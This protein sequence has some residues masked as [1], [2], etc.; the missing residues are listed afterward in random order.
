MLKYK[1]L[2]FNTDKEQDDSRRLKAV[3]E[4]DKFGYIAGY[5]SVFG[6]VDSAYDTVQRGAFAASI[7]AKMPKMLWQH[8][9]WQPIGIWDVVREDDYGL[10]VEG[11][12]IKN[13]E[14]PQ[15]RTAFALLKEG[16]ING[17][18]IGYR[19]IDTE[20]NRDTGIQTLIA[21]DLLEVSIVTFPANDLAEVANV[22]AQSLF[23]G[24]LKKSMHG[25]LD[26]LREFNKS[27]LNQ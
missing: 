25:L 7:A 3:G 14:V 12:I 27:L 21:L 23:S 4:D 16:S 19:E 18:S 20:Y 26:D 6:N 15:G 8:D 10:W 24:S 1:D 17:L 9:R 5:A 11:R 2:F 13:E 22:K